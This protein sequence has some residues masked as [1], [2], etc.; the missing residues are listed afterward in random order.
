MELK[1][2]DMVSRYGVF[3]QAFLF[4]AVI[5]NTQTIDH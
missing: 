2:A 4:A 1:L 3:F 5:E